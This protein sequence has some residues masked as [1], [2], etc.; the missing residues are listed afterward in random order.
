[1]VGYIKTNPMEFHGANYEIHMEKAEG[2]MAGS[3][4]WLYINNVKE[5]DV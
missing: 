4:G 1:M 3:S 2:D 5:T